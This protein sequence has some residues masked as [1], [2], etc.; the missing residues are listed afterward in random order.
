MFTSDSS[1]GSIP[2]ADISLAMS[3]TDKLQSARGCEG[4]GLYLNLF[5]PNRNAPSHPLPNTS[6]FVESRKI[7]DS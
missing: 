1:Y 6:M 2:L 3:L 5:Y 7:H 4:D